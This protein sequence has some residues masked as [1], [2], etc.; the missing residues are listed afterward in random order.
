MS[1]DYRTEQFPSSLDFRALSDIVADAKAGNLVG[2]LKPFYHVE[3]WLFGI[4]VGHGASPIPTPIP[5]P[6]TTPGSPVVGFAS[7]SP[8]DGGKV[9]NEGYVHAAH[10]FSEAELSAFA[11]P[12]DSRNVMAIADMVLAYRVLKTLAL[13]APELYAVVKAVLGNLSHS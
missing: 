8:L 13:Y 7:A 1:Y 4:F 11:S 6:N 9:Y 5:T 3:G 2:A 10:P 12:G